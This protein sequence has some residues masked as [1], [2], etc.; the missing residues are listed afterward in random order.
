MFKRLQQSRVSR[1]L[2]RA[3][4]IVLHLSLQNLHSSEDFLAL[5]LGGKYSIQVIR[6]PDAWWQHLPLLP[7]RV[8]VDIKGQKTNRLSSPLDNDRAEFVTPKLLPP[9]QKPLRTL[10][11]QSS[12]IA[13]PKSA[14]IRNKLGQLFRCSYEV[15]LS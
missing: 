2:R 8:P 12:S 9:R 4:H 6:G 5:A 10:K 11:R 13:L 15:I 14:P 3:E 1:Q 7:R